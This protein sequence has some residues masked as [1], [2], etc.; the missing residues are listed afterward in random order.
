MLARSLDRLDPDGSTQPSLST[1]H[2]RINP[3]Q[4]RRQDSHKSLY[5]NWR[6]VPEATRTCRRLASTNFCAIIVLKSDLG[7]EEKHA[8]DPTKRPPHGG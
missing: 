1:G 7:A 8:F 2:G 3:S 6:Q 4:K 5:E